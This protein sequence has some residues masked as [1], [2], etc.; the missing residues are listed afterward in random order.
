[1]PKGWTPVL[2]GYAWGFI[3]PSF[4]TMVQNPLGNLRV[5]VKIDGA[6]M[7]AIAS[8]NLCN[9]NRDALMGRAY[10]TLMNH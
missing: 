2:Y 7:L 6:Y 4:R 5:S 10:F 9:L 1:M 8:K 3:P